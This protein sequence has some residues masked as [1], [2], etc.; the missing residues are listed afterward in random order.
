[1]AGYGHSS[2]TG[3][4]ER[5][6]GRVDLLLFDADYPDASAALA[7]SWRIAALASE[8]AM[9]DARDRIRASVVRE[10]NE[11][12]DPRAA[13]VL[14]A[15]AWHRGC[16]AVAFLLA[17]LAVGLA[18]TLRPGL[19]VQ[20]MLLPAG[21]CAALSVALLWWLEPRRANGSLWG[22]RLPAV[23]SLVCGLLWLFSAAV[24]LLA[25]WGE[26]DGYRSLAPTAG[27]T[28][29]VASGVAALFLWHRGR[30]SDRSGAQSGTARTTVDLIDSRDEPEVLDRL[31]GWWAIAGPAA[32]LRDGARVRRV[33]IEVLARLALARIVPEPRARLARLED[34]PVRW[35]ERRR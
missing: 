8:P 10:V 5:T 19:T 7:D 22:T 13:R 32:L 25:R 9:R 16:L 27:L 6:L 12:R 4:D 2:V 29:L 28:L 20:V 26:I 21:L 14:P 17:A 30:R 3:L 35:T 33:R 34:P 1:M 15:T 18:T 11:R 23:L 24:D 31:D